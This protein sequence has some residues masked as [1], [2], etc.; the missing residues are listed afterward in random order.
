[1]SHWTHQLCHELEERLIKDR[2]SNKRQ[3]S[4][5]TVSALLR[6]TTGE[7]RVSRALPIYRYCRKKIAHDILQV[8]NKWNS[9]SKQGDW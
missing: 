1:M 7:A 6:E 5:L 9:A 2:D 4:S 8:M 3:A